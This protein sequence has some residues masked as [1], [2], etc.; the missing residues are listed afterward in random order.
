M[1]IVLCFFFDDELVYIVN[2]ILFRKYSNF[3]KE[4]GR[5]YVKFYLEK[6]IY[7]FYVGIVVN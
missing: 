3:V 2:F 4:C 5:V 7:N 1:K 6:V